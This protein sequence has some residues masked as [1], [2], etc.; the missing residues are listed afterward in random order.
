MDWSQ[1]MWARKKC[2]YTGQKLKKKKTYQDG[3]LRV[4][5]E[6]GV[7]ELY[8][9]D[10]KA[11]RLPGS[12]ETRT[13]TAAETR[14]VMDGSIS[15]LEFEGY[16]VEVEDAIVDVA[17]A[18]TE[19][20]A[21]ELTAPRASTKGLSRGFK[22]PSAAAPKPQ[23]LASH[24]QQQQRQGVNY[25][26]RYPQQAYSA[27]H[28]RP[29]DYSTHMSAAGGG[30]R[31]DDDELNDIW[32]SK[33]SSSPG[34]GSDASGPPTTAAPYT[35]P[36]TAPRLDAVHS[37]TAAAKEVVYG[38]SD[39][40]GR[41]AEKRRYEAE[42][43]EPTTGPASKVTRYDGTHTQAQAQAQAQTQ[44]STAATAAAAVLPPDSWAVP[45][46]GLGGNENVYGYQTQNAN[47]HHHHHLPPNALG[48]DL[49][50]DAFAAGIAP[51]AA[52][53]AATA[54]TATAAAVDLWE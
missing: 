53:A 49:Y 2:L 36:S 31:V 37:A 13:M 29:A 5:V 6:R 34:A 19:S 23:V 44:A 9:T 43:A 12:L 38:S 46:A 45:G 10:G 50:G 52:A 32:D 51:C 20:I 17:V 47:T 21:A 15:E 1:A 35:E 8:A 25:G 11:A 54:A 48:V 41:G 33:T 22:M 30:Y 42:V 18:G 27:V 39:G 4:N 28:E 16:L 40:P 7:C 3:V 14:G 26:E 24:Q